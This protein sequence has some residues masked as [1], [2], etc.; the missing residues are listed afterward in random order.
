MS[1]LAVFQKNGRVLYQMLNLAI[2]RKTGELCTTFPILPF[3][4]NGRVLYR[5]FNV[6]I[7]KGMG[8]FCTTCA[9][10][11]IYKKWESPKFHYSFMVKRESFVLGDI[12]AGRFSW[13]GNFVPGVFPTWRVSF[14]GMLCTGEF[15]PWRVKY[16]ESFQFLLESTVPG[17]I[18]TR[19]ILLRDNFLLESNV[20]REM[21][22]REKFGR[23]L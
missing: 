12:P 1:N 20:G 6:A 18:S 11:L 22:G 17:D 19:R 7:F 2:F 16:R 13:W 8:E 15:C 23:V 5:L 14:L 9:F 21:S 4:K 10:W 3:S